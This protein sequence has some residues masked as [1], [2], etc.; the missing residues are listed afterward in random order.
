MPT[1]VIELRIV[2][3]SP[4]DVVDE[5]EYADQIIREVNETVGQQSGLTLRPFRWEIDALP[6]FHAQGPQGTI[7]LLADITNCDFLV[8][9][10]WSRL[11]TPG[12][13]GR[14]GTEHEFH[15]AYES[16]KTKGRPQIILYFN[17]APTRV[18]VEEQLKQVGALL[19]FKDKLPKEALHCEYEG[20]LKFR[21]LFRKHLA[22]AALEF[23]KVPQPAVPAPSV[24]LVHDFD[25]QQAEQLRV[26]GAGSSAGGAI[27]ILLDRWAAPRIQ[28]AQDPDYSGLAPRV[29]RAMQQQHLPHSRPDPAVRDP[30]RRAAC[31]PTRRGPGLH[32]HR[33][34]YG[35]SIASDRI[36]SKISWLGLVG[37]GSAGAISVSN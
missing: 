20:A 5:R 37:D 9:I 24:R 6:K 7:D 18:T 2:I 35:T 16:W 21:E 26:P 22:K 33:G 12:P 14:T 27:F 11:G 25:A 31:H 19:Q 8:V 23:N 17:T 28:A 32:K 1:S 36:H 4:S 30:D 10:L 34:W 13:D 15:V 29:G 3:A